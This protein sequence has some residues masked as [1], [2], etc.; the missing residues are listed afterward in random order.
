MSQSITIIGGNT[1]VSG[2]VT[3]PLDVN[4][5][6]SNLQSLLGMSGAS[7]SIVGGSLALANVNAVSQGLSGNFTIP[8]NTT[9]L[10]GVVELTNTDPNGSVF[11]GSSVTGYTTRV[12]EQYSTLIDQLPGSGVIRGNSSQNFLAIFGKNA[13]ATFVPEG[14]SGTV[15]AGG[16]G[17]LISTNGL[18]SIDGS[19]DGGDTINSNGTGT[20]YTYGQ[21]AAPT[22]TN[23]FNLSG[24]T[25][26]SNVVGLLGGSNTVI[27]GGTADLVEGYSASNDV[28]S[29]TSSSSVSASAVILVSGGNVTVDAASS[30][31]NVKAFFQTGGNLYFVNQSTVQG[32]VGGDAP[33]ATGG[34]AT[35]FGGIGGGVFKGGSGGSNSLIGGFA[36]GQASTAGGAGLVTLVGSSSN[37]FLEAVRRR[38]I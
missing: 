5:N 6:V 19:S 28:V 20:I 29:V 2:L 31:S 37:N 7:G 10:P 15:I 24:N 23:G 1:S 11:G 30:S 22:S 4:F 14:G 38:M 36:P 17:D 32:L 8:A 27:A 16:S 26:P 18:W 13:N 35:V 25:P 21:G 34:S 3:V 12:P 33:N 9:G